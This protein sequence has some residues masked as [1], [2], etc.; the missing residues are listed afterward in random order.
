MPL[1]DGKIRSAF[2]ITEPDVASSDATNMQATIEENGDEIILNGTKWWSTGIGHPEC[3]VA[4]FMGLSDPKHIRI[5][6][7]F[8]GACAVRSPPV[9][10]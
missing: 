8:Y 2:C 5:F 1:L 7:T 6:T 9:T 10:T 4:I 3:K